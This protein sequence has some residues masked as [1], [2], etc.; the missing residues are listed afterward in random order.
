MVVFNE[1]SISDT[2]NNVLLI[3]LFTKESETVFNI[4]NNQKC[5]LSIKSTKLCFDHRNKWHFKIYSNSKQL[6]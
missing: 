5:F 6:F 2:V 4:A 3:F 1:L